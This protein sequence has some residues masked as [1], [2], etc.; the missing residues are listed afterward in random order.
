[1]GYDGDGRPAP[2][3]DQV[4]RLMHLWKA[5]DQVKVDEYLDARALAGSRLFHQLLQA[6]IELAEEGSDERA[7]LESISNHVAGKRPEPGGAGAG[8][9]HQTWRTVGGGRRLMNKLPWTPWHKVVGLRDD[10]RSGEMLTL[11]IFAA[12]LYDV[13]MGKAGRRSTPKPEEFFALTYPT[14]NLRELAKDV[15]TPPGRQ[16][17]QGRP[18]ARADL[19]RRQDP[20]PHHAATTS[21]ATRP[22]CPIC[23]PLRSSSS[24]SGCT[25]RTHA[26]PSCPSTSSTSRRAWRCAGRTARR[27]GCENPWSVLAFQIA[28]DDGLRLPAR[29]GQGRR[30]RQRP[31]REPAAV[32][33]LALPARKEASRRWC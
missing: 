28:G 7:L 17:R 2:L 33:L 25:R 12:D 23:R 19:R 6:L 14:F 5:G 1:M 32:E 22:S 16:E 15:L 29:R 27:A 13:V 10:L 11:A 9:G 20:H 24:T 18:P 3:I 21:S 30:A 26:W 8:L 4:H 31:G